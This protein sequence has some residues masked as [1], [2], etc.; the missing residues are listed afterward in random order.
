MTLWQ[1]KLAPQA[2]RSLGQLPD[3]VAT[4]IA[5]FM[6]GP[7]VENPRRVGKPLQ[8]ELVRYYSARQGTYRIIHQLNEE[9]H[10]IRVIRID[11]R[12]HVYRRL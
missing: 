2:Q 12:S 8:N 4:A 9:T 1:L 11:H 5:V 10:V 7:L 3:K 6:H